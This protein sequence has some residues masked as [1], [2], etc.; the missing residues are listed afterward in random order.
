MLDKETVPP[1]ELATAKFP[2]GQLVATPNALRQ[3]LH[4][5]ILAALRR[6]IVGD[7]GDLDEN[8]RKQNEFA[9][10]HGLRLLSVYHSASGVKFYIITEWDHSATTVLLP[11]DY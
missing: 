4:A 9:L 7:W 11:E 8:D 6:H 1:N 2:I 10:K 5:D 3:L